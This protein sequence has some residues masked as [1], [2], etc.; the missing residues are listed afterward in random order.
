[1]LQAMMD[2]ENQHHKIWSISSHLSA[3]RSDAKMTGKIERCSTKATD[4]RVALSRQVLAM[5][6]LIGDLGGEQ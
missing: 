1:M 6:N 5:R 4:K 2:L 3:P